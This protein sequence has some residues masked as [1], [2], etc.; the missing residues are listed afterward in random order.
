MVP[1]YMVNFAGLLCFSDRPAA[2]YIRGLSPGEEWDAV[3]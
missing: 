3:T 1:M 2:L